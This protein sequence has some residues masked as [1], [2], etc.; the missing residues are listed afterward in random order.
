MSE[1]KASEIR[2]YHLMRHR[3]EVAVMQIVSRCFERGWRVRV[4]CE[5]DAQAEAIAGYLWSASDR[6]FLPCG[7]K[8]DGRAQLQ[9]IWLSA[10]DENPNNATVSLILNEARP[11]S[12]HGFAM[13]CLL[14]DGNH[15]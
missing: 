2:F 3:L 7:T 4:L 12:W 15:P 10:A 5:D 1:T 9:P 6:K 11:R 14:F 8:L 13:S